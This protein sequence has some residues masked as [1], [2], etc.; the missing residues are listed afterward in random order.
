MKDDG[1]F[2]RNPHY[3]RLT[4][5]GH[6]DKHTGLENEGFFGV[7]Y[8]KGAEYRFSVWARTPGKAARMRVELVNP[9]SMGERHFDAQSDITVDSKEWKKYEVILKPEESC[10]KGR[11][12]I[13]LA[14]PDDTT[15]DLEHISLFPVDTWKGREGGL[16][17]DLAQKLHDLNPISG[18]IR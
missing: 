12:R 8:R 17:K 10:V 15:L 11:L 6:N 9:A 2:E 5:A 1:P 18:K 13:F 7:T 14:K 16:R 3:V 4:S